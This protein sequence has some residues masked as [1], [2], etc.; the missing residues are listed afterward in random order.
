M[1]K[2]PNICST[3]SESVWYLS[4]IWYSIEL[5]LMLIQIPQ[6]IRTVNSFSSSKLIDMKK[7]I[8]FFYFEM[9][10]DSMV[11]ERVRMKSRELKYMHKHSPNDNWLDIFTMC[12]FE[13]V[14]WDRPHPRLPKQIPSTSSRVPLASSVCMRVCFYLNLVRE[15]DWNLSCMK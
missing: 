12:W 1:L 13:F 6:C 8:S 5:I 7:I 9:R 10:L 11:V 4:E 14:C 15:Y 2:R 3:R